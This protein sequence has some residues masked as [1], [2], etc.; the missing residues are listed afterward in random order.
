[1]IRIL[2][3]NPV[4]DRVYYINNF[5]TGRQFH[6]INPKCYSGGKGVN[7]ARV[8][9]CLGE[10][11]VLYAFLGGTNGRRIETDM[12]SYGV[13]LRAFWKEEETR[14]TIN[15]IDKQGGG[16]TEITEPG[17]TVSLKEER[18]FLKLLEDEICQGDMIICSGLPANGMSQNIY[19]QVSQMCEEKDASCVLDANRQYLKGAFPGKYYFSKPNFEEMAKL[20]GYA[21]EES[22]TAIYRMGIKLLNLGVENL[23]VSMGAKGGLF[24]NQREILRIKVP[25]TNVISTIGS[26][27]AAVAGFCLGAVQKR[28]IEDCI[29]LAMACG[30]CNTRYSQVGYVEREEVESLLKE[31]VIEKIE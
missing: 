11:C 10:P 22:E 6:G 23:L 17:P 28:E 19:K 12:A 15:I 31:I 3:L 18:D 1:M 5:Q 26:G 20:F 16:E 4:I 21:G 2:C 14:S 29:R 30:I 8:L 13:Q 27:D 9:G 7:I 24:F 25:K